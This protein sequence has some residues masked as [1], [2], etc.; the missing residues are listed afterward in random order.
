LPAAVNLH[1]VVSKFGTYWRTDF[2]YW[3]TI[4]GI[5]KG[6]DETEASHEA[7][8]ASLFSGSVFGILLG[9]VSEIGFTGNRLFVNVGNLVPGYQGIFWCGIRIKPDQYVT[10][11]HVLPYPV[12][13]F[14]SQ[15]G[16]CLFIRQIGCDELFAV[17]VQFV[18]EGRCRVQSLGFGFG[19]LELEIHKKV[20]VFV[21]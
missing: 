11:F 6:V 1:D 15:P 3:R 18:D 14:L 9:K 5:F 16:F 7:Q 20:Y 21:K 17:T 8:V 2:T 10:G 19:H 13:G 12:V 4:N